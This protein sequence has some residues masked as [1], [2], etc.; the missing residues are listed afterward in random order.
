MNLESK[1][2]RF[3]QQLAAFE[4]MHNEEL[5]S[6][7]EKLAALK[8][9]QADEVKFLKE[10]LAA[11]RQALTASADPDPTASSLDQA[12][13]SL[14]QSPQPTARLTRRELFGGGANRRQT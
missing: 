3:E 13:P 12:H 2:Q 11:L 7:A 5:K 14:N 6:F 4:K 9:I 10:E 8:R 1:L